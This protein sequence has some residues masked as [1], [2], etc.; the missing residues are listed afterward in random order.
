M[1]KS[2]EMEVGKAEE[3]I[4]PLVLLMQCENFNERIEGLEC[5]REMSHIMG[6]VQVSMRMRRG[7]GHVQDGFLS[8]QTGSLFLERDYTSFCQFF[9][10]NLFTISSLSPLIH[11]FSSFTLKTLSTPF[12]ISNEVAGGKFPRDNLELAMH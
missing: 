6:Q 5:K 11:P 1:D 3:N 4:L 12:T 2:A 9:C 10:L 8:P 7:T